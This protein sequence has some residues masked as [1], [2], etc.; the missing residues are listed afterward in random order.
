LAQVAQ[1]VSVPDDVF[2]KGMLS[3]DVLVEIFSHATALDIVHVFSTVSLAW[4]AVAHREDLWKRV[5]LQNELHLLPNGVTSWR[6]LNATEGRV[7]FDK[8]INRAHLHYT[9][10]GRTVRKLSGSPD[11]TVA[12]VDIHHKTG[13]LYVEFSLTAMH[14]EMLIGVTPTPVQTALTSGWTLLRSS[15]IWAY[16][17]HRAGLQLGGTSFPAPNYKTNDTVGVLVDLSERRVIFTLNGQ[18]IPS[19]GYTSQRLARPEKQPDEETSPWS[20]HPKK[21]SFTEW[22]DGDWAVF[23]MLDWDDDLVTIKRVLRGEAAAL[24]VE[25]MP[26]FQPPQQVEKAGE[27]NQ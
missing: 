11:T 6:H 5:C 12:L 18:T 7:R 22:P 26:A 1:A 23:C 2:L 20:S 13:R 21:G 19:T 9:M 10:T 15:S 8:L 4:Y 14:D 25:D 16:W 24:A 3:Q 27:D 17:D